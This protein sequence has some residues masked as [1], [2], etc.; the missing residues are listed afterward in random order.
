MMWN[1][2]NRR[3]IVIILAVILAASMVLALLMPVLAENQT[4]SL[5]RTEGVIGNDIH[6]GDVDVSGL[7]V[8]EAKAKVNEEVSEKSA[9]TLT[10][11]LYSGTSESAV[12][13]AIYERYW[14]I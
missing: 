10:V 12:Y 1:P 8:D 7:T 3:I 11:S 14:G 4:D 5:V 2:K 13:A 9:Q 6:V